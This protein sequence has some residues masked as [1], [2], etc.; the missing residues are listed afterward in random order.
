[1]SPIRKNSV[2]NRASF[3]ARFYLAALVLAIAAPTLLTT[4]YV[5]M[6]YADAER[7]RLEEQLRDEARTIVSALDRRFAGLIDAM[8]VLAQTQEFDPR[9]LEDFYSR[10]GRARDVLGRNVILRDLDG[11]QLVNPRL[12]WGQPLPRSA[13]PED[14]LAITSGRAQVSGVFDSPVDNEKIVALV[15]PVV[16]DGKPIY[17]LNLSQNLPYFDHLLREVRLP[18]Q[19]LALIMDTNGIVIARSRDGQ[20]FVGRPGIAFGP[21]REG[22]QVT[23]NLDGD[24]A[25]VGWATSDITGWRASASVRYEVIDAPRREALTTIGL[26][27]AFVI[28]LGFAL[29]WLVGARLSRSLRVLTHASA[30]LGARAPVPH[31]DTP[32]KEANEIGKELQHA[33]KR[34]SENEARLE[35]ALVSAKMYSFEYNDQEPNI[36]RSASAA[37]V[38]GDDNPLLLNGPRSYLRDRIHPSDR[39]RFVRAVEA[40]HT[41]STDYA[42][43]F[44][45]IR[46]DGETIWLQVNGVCAPNPSGKG[47]RLT[48]FARDITTRK[49]SQVRQSLLVREL[50]H[51]VKNNLATVLALANLS[52]R[53]AASVED[54]QSKLRARIQSMARAHSLLS[55]NAFRPAFLRT[56]L[57]DE[58]E[59]YAQGDSDR[60]RIEGP[61]V[62]L[63][64]EAAFALGMAAHEL[65]T[66]AGKYGALSTNEGRLDITCSIIEDGAGDEQHKRLRIEWRESGGPPVTPPARKGFGSRL[67][68][69]VI[70][71]QLKGSVDLRYEPDGLVAIIEAR[72]DETMGSEMDLELQN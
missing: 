57:R 66:N 18:P 37:V 11:L 68:Q 19:H 28:L 13:R 32:L 50:H 16:K 5:L 72:L 63:P 70:G 7:T 48:G 65:A 26:V 10:A 31:V 41:E 14:K 51:R 43:Q 49:Q 71:E 47:S 39:E 20:K 59:P 60:I 17:L 52:G 27:S 2:R 6:R 45:Y 22:A 54:Y 35:K 3:P 55:E 12:P 4:G 34:L 53:N 40:R 36:I 9:G 46:L 67:L 64:P 38:L 44:R 25:L 24:H 29:A 62:D 58:L 42:I 30:A 61:D 8:Q 33:A 56:L 23:T 15:I 21:A 1:M 69:S